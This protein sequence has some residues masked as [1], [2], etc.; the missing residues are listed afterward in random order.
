MREVTREQLIT[1]LEAVVEGLGYELADI[2]V[3]AGAHG[4]LR[5]FI[6]SDAG[7]TLEDCERVSRQ[8][9]ALLDV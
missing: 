1:M 9:A 3:R 8:V 6:D 7:I 2:E 4:L 5:L